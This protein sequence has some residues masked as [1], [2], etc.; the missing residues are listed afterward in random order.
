MTAYSYLVLGV[1]PVTNEANVGLKKKIRIT[2]AKHIHADTLNPNTIR[3]RVVN[4][5]AVEYTGIYHNLEKVYEVTPEEP[6][7][8][9]TQYQLSIAG[10]MDG[11]LSI[12]NNYLPATR[13]Y[14]FV[15]V[16]QKEVAPLSNL[17]LGQEYLFVFAR[18]DV[19]DGF[20]EDASAHF[21]VKLSSSSNPEALGLWPNNEF[22]GKTRSAE[23][24]IPYKVN[25][26]EAYYV[27]V[28]AVSSDAETD[29]ISQQ[30]YV[31]TPLLAD[32]D[33]ALPEELPLELEDGE[34]STGGEIPPPSTGVQ[35]LSIVDQHP[36]NGELHRPEEIAILFT[37]AVDPEQ[38]VSVDD[39]PHRLFY[40][41]E[42]PQKTSLS[43]FDLRGAYKSRNGLRGQ[44][45]VDPEMPNLL[46]FTPEDGTAAFRSGK[47]YT[48]VLSK[49]I[50]DVN[51]LPLGF[52]YSYG[53]TG[54]P[55]NL[56]GDLP[57]IKETLSKYNLE[58][59]TRFLQSL[60]RKHSQ[61]A[62]DIWSNSRTYDEA[63]LSDGSAPYF[64][65]EYVNTQVSID[66]LINGGASSAA[67]G[68]GESIKL[69]DLSVTKD[70]AD[71]EAVSISS[72]I[73]LLGSQLKNWEDLLHG[74][75]NRGYARPLAAVKGEAVEPYP[76][77]MTRSVLVDFDG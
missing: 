32:D 65:H 43:V 18:W 55:E 12:D 29:W 54:T 44:I 46:V 71:G 8:P 64:I 28:R 63:L 62:V 13:T 58:F 9:G 39:E 38:F 30:I 70:A 49:D 77:T 1:D 56:Y 24:S 10:G 4:G 51:G 35:Q 6:L 67:N 40:V 76:E 36:K 75:S 57:Q 21:Q 73:K 2:F 68:A 59:S 15:T 5:A 17:V 3:L 72:V 52:T 16:P 20:A 60:M 48:V 74:V 45:S 26:E 14:E 23:L 69:G 53:F 50:E 42:A 66:S 25:G 34:D 19:P 37:G 41:V 47:D 61:Y 7:Q 27:H 31:D 22:E 33:V 11:V